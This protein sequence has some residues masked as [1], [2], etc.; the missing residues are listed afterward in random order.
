MSNF[1]EAA[2]K[3]TEALE[4]LNQTIAAKSLAQ[5]QLALDAMSASRSSWWA[6]MFG[7]AL[8]GIAVVISLIV[9]FF[10][11]QRKIVKPVTLLTSIT[12]SFASKEYE[13][14]VV[15]TDWDNEIGSLARALATLRDT[16]SEADELYKQQMESEKLVRESREQQAIADQKTLQ[17]QQ[18]SAEAE[19]QASENKQREAEE[20]KSKVDLLLEVVESAIGGD[21]SRQVEVHGDNAIGR[22]GT[23][24][25]RLLKTFNSNMQKF[26]GS[27]AGLAQASQKLTEL[28][29][30]LGNT[31]QRSS[32]QS[33]HVSSTAQQVSDNVDSVASATVEM[34]A[35]IGEISSQSGHANKVVAEA[36]T[37]TRKTEQ[38][39]KELSTASASIGDVTKVI[40]SIAGQTNLLALNA[41]IEA[42][43]AGEAGKGFAVVASEV[44]EL[45]NETAKAT[46]E[47]ENRIAS[48]QGNTRVAATAVV[49]ISKII[50]QISEVQSNITVAISE[51]STTTRE[52]SRIVSE[53]ATG[54]ST[55]ALSISEV[56]DGAKSTLDSVDEARQAAHDL[57]RMSDELNQLVAYY[58]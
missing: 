56:A 55:I 52:I 48:I 51:Q 10:Y 37:L 47:I 58:S 53:A 6:I 12:E 54:S 39:V 41:T 57:S 14:A 28:G 30:R 46:K 35:S 9:I 49:D 22:L 21:L 36:V 32:E 24:L 42:A 27:A 23:G 31:A 2:A 17:E 11:L 25:D 19:R 43:R 8:I 1:D 44:K 3:Q 45:A 7:M 5:Q 13:R 33:E 38:T 50:Q 16:A 4:T 26:N 20:L 40:A 29:D 34:S 18:R 15:H